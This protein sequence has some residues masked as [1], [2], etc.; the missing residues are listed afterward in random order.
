M[1]N[2]IKILVVDD[3]PVTLEETQ[4]VLR[5]AGYE[6]ITRDTAVGTT[7][8]LRRLRPDVLLLDVNMPALRGDRLARFLRD[9]GKGGETA[10]ILHSTMDE[11]LLQELAN[12]VGACGAIHKPGSP[13]RLCMELRAILS[14]IHRPEERPAPAPVQEPGPVPAEP[15]PAEPPAVGPEPP[16]LDQGRRFRP[17]TVEIF[18]RLAP[19]QAAAVRARA[20]AGDLEALEQ[21]AHR[22]GGSCRAVGASQLAALCASIEELARA[23]DRGAAQEGAQRIDGVLRQVAEALRAHAP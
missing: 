9:T 20:E 8:Y 4:A 21:A 23:G 19:V 22:L 18:L 16:V 13:A 17:A 5:E 14:R 12:Q 7:Q 3:D 6:V 11:V 15:P 2:P 10:V 1:A